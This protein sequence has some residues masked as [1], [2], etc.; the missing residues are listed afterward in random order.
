MIIFFHAATKFVR[1][2]IIYLEMKQ[3][4]A[5]IA[6]CYNEEKNLNF[7]YDRL[8]QTIKQLNVQYKIYFIDDGSKDRT[9]EI[10]KTMKAK[11]DNIYAIKLSRNFGHQNAISVGIK[12][13]EADYVI[14]LDVDLQDPPELIKDMYDKM[15]SSNSN[16]IYAQRNR[17]NENFFKKI[18]SRFFYK[19]FNI[20]S[21][22]KILERTSDFRMIDKK[23]LAELKKFS[24]KNPFYRGIVS[25]IGFKSDKILFDRPNRVDGVS[26]WT[27]KKMINFSIDGIMSFSNFPMRFSFYLSFLMSFIFI[28]LSLYTVSFYISGNTVVPAWTSIGLI[29]SF[30][31]IIIFFILGLISEYV[32]R[33]HLET[34]NRPSFIVE[35]E[36]K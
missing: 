16:I 25:W 18:T 33:I 35:E 1:I 19:T 6:P 32:G 34:K 26:G 4:L 27:L 11:D 21:E 36:I 7:F 31:N 2:V 20:L 22:V 15:I 9:W 10:I 30:F 17:S 13:A 14:F 12:K 5:I 29:I 28:F 23:V 8:L 24:E 3:I